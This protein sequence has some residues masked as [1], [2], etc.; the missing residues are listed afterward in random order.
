MLHVRVDGPKAVHVSKKLSNAP[1]TELPEG[2]RETVQPLQQA[3]S[4]PLWDDVTSGTSR[5]KSRCGT[6]HSPRD[7]VF[8]VPAS[9]TR[10]TPILRAEA[11]EMT[12]PDLR[13]TP[14]SISKASTGVEV[15]WCSQES[16]DASTLAC[17]GWYRL[18][19]YAVECVERHFVKKRLPATCSTTSRL[20]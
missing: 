2:A 4:G 11:K 16:S 13:D 8:S 6:S 14:Y 19:L 9:I 1:R 7:I 18:V 3:L 10:S 17:F 20:F 12:W 5:R 15:N